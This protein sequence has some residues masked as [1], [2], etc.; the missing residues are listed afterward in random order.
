MNLNRPTDRNDSFKNVEMMLTK[1][2]TG[3]WFAN[4]AILATKNRRYVTGV[5]QSPNDLINDLDT[6]WD[7]SYRLAGGYTLPYGV[8]FSTLYQAYNGIARQRTNVFRATDPA[9]GPAFPSSSTITLRVEPFGAHRAPA[10]HIVNLRGEKKFGIGGSKKLSLALDAFN[11]FN[12]NVAGRRQQWV[13]H[14]RRVR[15]DLRLRCW[16]CDAPGAALRHHVRV[17]R[18][19]RGVG[20]WLVRGATRVGDAVGFEVPG[21]A[22]CRLARDARPCRRL[23]VHEARAGETARVIHIVNWK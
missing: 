22:A 9:G 21:R 20:V 1:R 8:D 6:T 4:T 19:D 17:L 14:Y 5:V 3:K 16:H 12:S 18:F 11:A 7:V 15:A 13:G 10:R 23:S 2:P